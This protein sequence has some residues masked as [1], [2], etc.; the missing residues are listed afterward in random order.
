[1][2]ALCCSRGLLAGREAS[3]LRRT[4]VVGAVEAAL[5]SVVNIST[6]A[7]IRVS[8]PFAVE[9]ERFFALQ[10][11]RLAE[12][13]SVGSGIIVDSHGLILTNYHV[14][15]R[16][17]NIMVRLLDGDRFPAQPVA[18]NVDSDLC[19]LQLTGDLSGQSLVALAFALPDDLLLGETVVTVGNPF[20]LENSVS[21]GVLSARNRSYREGEVA[22]D[23]ILQTDAAINPGNS[24]GPLV[25]LDGELI[26]M[27]VSIRKDAEGI[28]FAI[29]LRRIEAV[30]ASW[31]TP[32][33][34]SSG[35]CGFS[36]ATA[37]TAAGPTVRVEQVWDGS[38]AARA[39]LRAGDQI[40]ALN[41]ERT[42]RALEV[43]R[44]LWRLAAGDVACVERADGQTL[45]VAV[46]EMSAA[47]LVRQRLGIRVQPLTPGLRRALGLA[48]TIQGLVITEV[49]PDSEFATRKVRWGDMVRRGDLIAQAAGVE[50]MSVEALGRALAGTRSGSR[51]PL[52]LIAVD[53]IRNQVQSS[54][55]RIDV[56]LN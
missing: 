15:Q 1:V 25:N 32:P 45:N 48:G 43:G 54:Y 36:F 47:V 5:P 14:V 11:D 18:Y 56:T 9:F 20:G 16:A 3:A 38:P 24:G 27:N 51:L 35:Y 8:D 31:L 42:T 12:S 22:F 53:T 39:G 13:T 33:R 55:I 34:F 46:E 37:M 10:A 6:Q 30:L 7:V 50:T 49:F 40:V 19:L 4:P 23:D 29:P 52:V 41:G 21:T 44:G 17:S 2:A 26:G 28:G